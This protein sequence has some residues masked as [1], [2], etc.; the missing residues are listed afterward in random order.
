MP[1]AQGVVIL[2]IITG[3]IKGL[4]ARAAASGTDRDR[5]PAVPGGCYRPSVGALTGRGKGK[6]GTVG[7]RCASAP[8]RSW[9][10]CGHRG[11]MK[12]LVLAGGKGTRL[13]PLTHTMQKALVP[14]ANR[15]VLHYVM[16]HS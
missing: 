1:T 3:K 16:R 11:C 5:T 4:R 8:P 10:P 6:G 7:Q 14:V 13:R 9:I 2:G 12:A 15:P